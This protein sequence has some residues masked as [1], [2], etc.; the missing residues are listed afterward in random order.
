VPRAEGPAPALGQA[1]SVFID[2]DFGTRILRV[3][4]QNSFSGDPNVDAIQGGGWQTPFSADSHKFFL[5]S[6]DG[7][8]LF[9]RFD[10]ATFT[11]TIIMDPDHPFQ[12]LQL[13]G[14][15][16]D[17]FSYQNPDLVYGIS[18][19]L[20]NHNIVQYDFSQ[21]TLAVLANIDSFLP[22]QDQN[23]S[24]YAATVYNDYY[25]VN[26]ATGASHYV[27]VYNKPTNQAALIDLANSAFKNFNS[28][29][30]ISMKGTL[31][32]V[33]L[34][35]GIQID[36]SGRYVAISYSD[37]TDSNIYVDL[38]TGTFSNDPYCHRVTGFAN[39]AANC[40]NQN[41]NDSSGFY[42]A[43]LNDPAQHRFLAQNPNGPP[44]WNTDAHPS[45]NNARP[46]MALPFVTDMRVASPSIFPVRSWDDELIAVATDGSNKVWRF[47]HMHAVQTGY[48]YTTPFAH[49]S[50]DGQYALI[51]SNWGGTLGTA[52]EDQGTYN[53]SPTDQKRVDV[54][55]IELNQKYA[56]PA[57]DD[58]PPTVPVFQAGID[59]SQNISGTID[60]TA[61]ASDNVGLA[62]MRYAVDGRWQ[63]EITTAP[64]QFLLDTTQL[65]N[66][67]HWAQ[68]YAHDAQNNVSVSNIIG[69][70][71]KNGGNLSAPS[72]TLPTA[73]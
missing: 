2:P 63:P 5:N 53:G 11:A 36:K 43:N 44:R 37:S 71:V 22:D 42:V 1:N 30:F 40:G 49:V 32:D 4:D 54:F 66:G 72:A 14:V 39:V 55:L 28:S 16:V 52:S 20:A 10:P 9:Y 18:T 25:D 13:N 24:G 46:N 51:D 58:V 59:G 38:Q 17:G 62:A 35:H 8:T 47:A 64:F 45:W 68:A 41:G 65:P 27:V 50:P 19:G 69:F 48:Y 61:T 15:S 26:F 56:V 21:N 67:Y 12:P 33:N 34:L 3:S 60:L 70:M 6:G 23:W 31:P 73:P 29:T 7:K 57:V